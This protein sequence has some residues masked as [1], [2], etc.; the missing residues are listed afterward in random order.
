MQPESS[1]RKIEETYLFARERYA[2]IGV[3][4]DE[5]LKALLAIPVSIPCWQGD[6]VGGFEHQETGLSD[7]IRCTGNY[8]GKARTAREL[9]ADLDAALSLIPGAHRVNLHAIYAE[10]GGARVER[11]ELLPEHFQNWIDWARKKGMGLDFN[12]TFFSHPKAG[13]GLTLSSPDEGVRRFWLRHGRACRRISETMGRELGTPSVMNVWIPDGFKDIPVDRKSARERLCASLDELFE[14]ELDPAWERDAL[15]PKLFG[16]GSESCVIGSHEFYLGYAIRRKKLFCLDMG[17][18][19]PTEVVSDKLS[20]VLCFLDEVLLHV[21][22][23]VRWDSDH[24]PILDDELCAL[25]KELVR[26]DYLDR[27][28]I[29]LDFFDASIN[30]VAAWAIGGRSMGKALCL[31]LLEPVARLRQAE[32]RGDYTERLALLEALKI[33]PFGAVWDYFCL[34]ADVPVESRWLEA[35]R[36]YEKSVLAGRA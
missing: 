3:D 14:D 4:T 28:H 13:S 19:H 26:G 16:I 8:P 1:T 23:P 7:G 6:D 25:A 15:E 9:R 35:A 20:S 24:V 29:G 33:M 17:H 21:S 10:T 32:T 30:R 34:Q 36:A 27:V 18:Y 5:S 22:R 31:A 2:A 12:P 11:D